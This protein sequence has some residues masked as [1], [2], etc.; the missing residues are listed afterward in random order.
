[1]AVARGLRRA[2]AFAARRFT[3]QRPRHRSAHLRREPRPRF[4]ACHRL[5]GGLWFTG[6]R[7]FCAGRR[8]RGFGRA[9]GRCDQPV[10][11]LYGGQADRAWRN[12]ARGIGAHGRSAG[13]NPYRGPKNQCAVFAPCS[14]QRLVCKRAAGHRPDCARSGASFPPGNRATAIGDSGLG[15]TGIEHAD[16]RR[17][18]T[19]RR[20]ARPLGRDRCLAVA[21]TDAPR[22]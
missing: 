15:R 11:R 10:L 9:T 3:H 14:A 8:T 17:K 22:V 20:V 6:A 19:T 5:H 12:P 1:M 4:S 2:A 13:A 7:Q 16:E 21:R 18:R